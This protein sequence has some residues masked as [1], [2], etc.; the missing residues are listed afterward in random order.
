MSPE[1]PRHGTSAGYQ[2]HARD[3]EEPCTAC[4]RARLRATKRL[5]LEKLAGARFVYTR[6][7]LNAVLEPWLALGLG[8]TAV[9]AAAGLASQRGPAFTRQN[10]PVRRGTYLAVAA[11]TEADFEPGAKVWSDLTRTRIHSL[12]AAGHQLI[13]MP[14]PLRGS[15]RYRDKISVAQAAAVR[16]YYADHQDVDG[17]SLHTRNRARGAGYLPPAAWDDPGTLAW[18]LGW[19]SPLLSPAADVVDEVAVQRILSGEW[20]HPANAAERTEV[21]RR[22]AMGGGS[23]AQLGRLTG[24]KP[25]RY[26]TL[27]DDGQVAS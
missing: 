26:Y 1:D 23:L 9:A 25:E 11:V 7:E 10:G 22:W 8:S 24:W 18:P 20:R 15:W 14:I 19:T 17:P 16:D 21:A 2:T 5:K 13:D 12:M 6:E 27:R 3:H 4:A